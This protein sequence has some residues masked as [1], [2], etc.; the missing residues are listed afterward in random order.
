[1]ETHEVCLHVWHYV[2]LSVLSLI[3]ESPFLQARFVRQAKEI[4]VGFIYEPVTLM[5]TQTVEV[6]AVIVL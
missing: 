6:G 1:M 4:T 5:P 2:C 3:P